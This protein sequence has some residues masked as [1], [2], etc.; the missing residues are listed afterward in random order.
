MLPETRLIKNKYVFYFNLIDNQ[1]FNLF[2]NN[3]FQFQLDTEKFTTFMFN[4][5]YMCKLM[6]RKWHYYLSYRNFLIKKRFE[7]GRQKIFKKE[8]KIVLDHKFCNDVVNCILEF[9]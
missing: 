8:L 1:R 7:L 3:Y 9:I 2:S 5:N 6:I 4:I